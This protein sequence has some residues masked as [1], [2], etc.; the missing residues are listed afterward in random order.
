MSFFHKKH[1]L[2]PAFY[3]IVSVLKID[4]QTYLLIAGLRLVIQAGE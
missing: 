3:V 2:L 1:L 4:E